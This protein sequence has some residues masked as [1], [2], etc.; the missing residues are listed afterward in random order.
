MAASFEA[1]RGLHGAIV[2]GWIEDQAPEATQPGLF[3]LLGRWQAAPD[4]PPALLWHS[5]AQA[6][7]R[8]GCLDAEL[9][10]WSTLRSLSPGEPAFLVRLAETQHR[11]GDDDAARQLLAAVPPRH[12]SRLPALLLL[13]ELDG[14]SAAEVA[15]GADE[16]A[17]PLLARPA[18]EPAHHQLVRRLVAAG[19]TGRAAAF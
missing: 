17:A 19:L 3:D 11:R 15:A 1:E 10:C 2:A 18:W 9:A 14:T 4:A 12:P 8:D 16:L 7:R 13:M 6:L 5:V